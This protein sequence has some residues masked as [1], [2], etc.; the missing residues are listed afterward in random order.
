MRPAGFEPASQQAT[1][2]K[3]TSQDARAQGKAVVPSTDV[4]QCRKICSADYEFRNENRGASGCVL[5]PASLL[6]FP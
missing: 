1:D 3:H 5:F 6:A 4:I 2:L